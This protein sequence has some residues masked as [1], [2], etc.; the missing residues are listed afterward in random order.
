MYHCSVIVV[1]CRFT[2]KK[3][4]FYGFWG[5]LNSRRVHPQQFFQN[6]VW[7]CCH[8]VA[9]SKEIVPLICKENPV[10]FI[11][12]QYPMP[13]C[14]FPFCLK[15]FIVVAFKNTCR[16]DHFE[17]WQCCVA[18]FF[19]ANIFAVLWAT[20]FCLLRCSHSILS[21]LD[22]AHFESLHIVWDCV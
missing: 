20:V 4:T 2:A 12:T 8:F 5:I 21:R 7:G 15:L 14:S 19:K 18:W 11:V 3:K 10:P 22:Y 16:K 13:H 9:F 17:A 6:V 1:C